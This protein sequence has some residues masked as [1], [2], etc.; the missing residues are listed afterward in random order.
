VNVVVDGRPVRAVAQ[1]SKQAF[2]YVFDR[3]TGE[4][5][6]PIEERPVPQSLIPGERTSP[7][8]PFPTRPAAFDLQG[9]SDETLIDLTPELKAEAWEIVRQY[10]H[11]PLY[12]PPSLKGTI[13]LPGWAGGAEWTGAAVD[14]ETGMIY[15]PSRTSPMAVKLKK[16]DP[17]ETEFDFVRARGMGGLQGPRGLPL[18]KPPF[19]RITAIDLNTGEH[20]WMVPFGDGLRQSIIDKWF[21]DPGPVGGAMPQ[22]PLL[23]RTLLFVPEGGRQQTDW[24][25]RVFDKNNGGTIAELPLPGPA[26]GAPMTYMADG[27][28]FIVLATGYADNARLVA[29]SLPD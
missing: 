19:S 5:I 27:K 1:V 22:G 12:T 9:I 17:E 28:Q 13:N 26:T 11:G 6:W 18:T 16:G 23:T 2:I 7:T 25:L 24:L 20:R 21:D 4:P 8:Q 14:P 29:L 3:V 10:E 15:I